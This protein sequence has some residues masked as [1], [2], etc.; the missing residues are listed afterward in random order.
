MVSDTAS[1]HVRIVEVGPRDGL[2]NVA[3]TIS[4]PTKL[5]LIK[6]LQQTGLQSI[7]VTSIVSARAIPQLADCKTVL[8]D[9]SIQDLLKNNRIRAPVL[10]PNVKGLD[11]ALAHSVRE[12]AVFVSASEGFSRANINCS[13]QQGLDRARAVAQKAL[14]NQQVVRGYVNAFF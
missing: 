13:V 11:I 9:P 14:Q 6:R 2:Q 5:E 12:V 3:R 7:E 10:I 1:D 4:T 8:S